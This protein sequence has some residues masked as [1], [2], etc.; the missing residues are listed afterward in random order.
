MKK[1][2]VTGNAGA[3]KSTFS[4]KLGEKLKMEVHGLDKIVWRP[5]WKKTPDN[6]KKELIKK[7]TDG[8]E[9]IIDGVSQDVFN[10]AE[11]VIF[12][13][14]PK[15]VCYWRVFKRNWKY[16]F[17]SRPG[18]PENCPE[19]LIMKR[20]ALIIWKFHKNYRPNLLSE[21]KKHE[22]AK[23]IVHINS[24]KLLEDF[25]SQAG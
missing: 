7:I 10:E 4:Q 13:D 18:L 2:L 25:L 8:E 5:G 20:L 3:G 1:I 19:I 12:L 22:Q 21:M 6:E 17:S 9:W 23:I 24:N 15:R 11:V 16:L 14:F